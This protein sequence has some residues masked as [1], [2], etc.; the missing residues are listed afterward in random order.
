MKRVL[1]Y[2]ID[3][4][5]E[6][7]GKGYYVVVPALPGC[8]SQGR[9]VEEARRNIE[10]AVALHIAE[11]KRRKESIPHEGTAFQSTIEIAA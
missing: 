5:P 8:F 10:E 7:D 6:E 9:T 2:S 4:L 1:R 3:I 11:L